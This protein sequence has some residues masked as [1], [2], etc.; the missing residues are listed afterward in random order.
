MPSIKKVL[1]K[2]VIKFPETNA[3]YRVSRLDT[4]GRSI[5]SNSRYANKSLNYF[6]KKPKGFS[7]FSIDS[8]E[9]LTNQP[10][11]QVSL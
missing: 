6:T 11:T 7:R 8:F 4:E 1:E 9:P 10:S 3:S 5:N 2:K